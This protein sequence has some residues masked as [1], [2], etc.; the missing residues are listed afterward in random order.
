[1][2]KKNHVVEFSHLDKIYFPK[3]GITKK[4][5]IE[6]YKKIFDYLYPH[7]QDRLIV[8]HR[9]PD[10]IDGENFSQKQIPDYFPDW[11]DRETIDLKKGEKQTLVIISNKETLV[12]LANQAV[13]VYHAWLSMRDQVNKPNKIVFDFDP[14]DNNIK[15]LRFVVIK[16]KEKLEELGLST[17]L[18]TTGSR[19]YHIIVP[20][21]PE[22]SF[23]VVQAFA[24]NIAYQ[25]AREYP[26][27][28]T[29]EMSESKRGDKIF[30]DY[31]R[32][33]YGQTSVVPY[34]LRAREGAPVATPLDWDE[35]ENTAPQK[36][37]MQNIFKRLAQKDDVWGDIMQYAKKIIIK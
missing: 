7:V 3:A 32:N 6:Y 26:Q 35:L 28:A 1:M 13:L 37:T 5:V 33:S 4:D 11:I 30:I 8:M 34:S 19:G 14:S 10:G 18:M 31:L 15:A 20:I 17:F 29:I 23:E 27:Y 25:I 21:I 9:Y 24:K 12:Y 22:H 36:Y 2:V 16:V